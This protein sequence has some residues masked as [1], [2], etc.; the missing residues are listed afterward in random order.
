MNVEEFLETI[1]NTLQFD[2]KYTKYANYL[3]PIFSRSEINNLPQFEFTKKVSNQRWENIELRVPVPLINKANE[4]KKFIEDIISYVYTDTDSHALGEIIIKPLIMKSDIT[5]LVQNEVFF[6][7]IE[8]TIIQGIREAKYL[9]W[10]AVAWFTN[11]KIYN[12]LIEKKKS[13]ISIRII[14]SEEESNSKLEQ[15]LKDNFTTVIYP[16]YGRNK[17]NR[18]HSKFCIVDMEYVMHGSYN[19]TDTANS[20]SETWCTAIDREYV[21]KFANQFMNLYTKSDD[22]A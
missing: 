11:E 16:R 7:K 15:K 18:M 6:D 2:S 8:N 3:L 5:E 10:A 20:N 19:W 17:Y 13:G 22:I 14:I 9:I 12:E 4:H 1:I 21:K